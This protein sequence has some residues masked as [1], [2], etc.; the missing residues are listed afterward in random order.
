VTAIGSELEGTPASLYL[1]VDED[2]L[3]AVSA[4]DQVTAERFITALP[5]A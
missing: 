3:F 2:I 5:A 4:A 1:F